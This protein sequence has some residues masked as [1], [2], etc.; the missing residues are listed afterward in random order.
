MG[1]ITVLSKHG[2]MTDL[3]NHRMAWHH[4]P[5][6]VE[7]SITALMKAGAVLQPWQTAGQSVRA[8]LLHIKKRPSAHS[9]SIVIAVKWNLKLSLGLG[10]WPVGCIYYIHSHFMEVISS[11]KEGKCCRQWLL[12]LCN[13]QQVA[14]HGNKWNHNRS[15]PS[16]SIWP[17][18]PNSV[19]ALMQ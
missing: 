14:L 5:G 3:E 6:E 16:A 1:S 17:M 4:N 9:W 2:N 8:C 12:N 19:N 10:E 7:G 13:I 15:T 18:F 11:G